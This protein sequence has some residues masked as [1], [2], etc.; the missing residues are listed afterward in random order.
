MKQI[1][2]RNAGARTTGAWVAAVIAVT[3]LVCAG[4]ESPASSGSGDTPAAFTGLTANG[5]ATETTTKLTLTFDKDITGLTAADITLTAGTT[6]VVKGALAKLS[7]T[8][9]YELAVSGIRASG[10]ITVT[11]DK[12]G[13]AISPASRN[14]EVFYYA[15]PAT[16]TVAFSSVAANGSATVT[17]TKLTLTFDKDIAGLAA[18]DITL[19]AGS[20]GTAKGALTKA[21]GTGVYELAVSGITSGG[22]I[23]VAAAKSGYSF[24]P[25]SRNVTVFYYAASATTAAAFSSVAANGS[26]TET[27]TK[28]TL[29]FDKDIAGL[30]AGDIIL[31]PGSTGAAKGALTK[32][33]GTG[34]YELAVSG[35]TSGGQAMVTVT[36]SGYSFTPGS[37]NVTVY[38][39]APVITYTV[40][41][42]GNAN[43]T[44]TALTLAFSADPGSLAIG[45]ITLGGNASKGSAALTGSGTTRTLSS[46]TVSASGNA[47]VSISR[48]G[49]ESVSKTVQVF[50]EEAIIDPNPYGLVVKWYITQEYANAE[51]AF[52]G[53]LAYE[54]TADGRILVLGTALFTYTATNNAITVRTSGITM[55]TASYAIDGTE[56]TLSNTGTSG[57]A[58]GTYYKKGDGGITYTVTANGNANTTT[59]ALTFAFSADPGSL[60]IND[61]T[62]SG[63]ASKGSATLTGS[64]TTRTLALITV[65]ASGSATVSISRTGIESGS[66]TVQVY[67]EGDGGG[68]ES[69]SFTDLTANGST[70]ETTTI[71]TLTFDKD[72]TGLSADD[73]I[74]TG[75]ST[76]AVKGTLTKL[77]G[78]GVYELAVN[79]ISAVG[80]VSIDISKNGYTITPSSR[81]VM[82]LY[83][84]PPI[85]ATFSSLTANGSATETTTKLTLTFDKNITGLSEAD[86]TLT[87]G[88]TNAVKGTLTKL[89][90]TGVYELAVSGIITGG[91]VSVSVVKDGYIISPVSRDIS[92]FY[93]VSMTFTGLTAN[94]S[95]TVTTT[96]LTLTFDQ[97]ISG[98]SA[99]DITLSGLSGITKGALD[100]SGS[101]YTL[102]V[103]GFNA[104]GELM[105]AISKDGYAISPAYRNV[106]L[107]KAPDTGIGIGSASVKLYLDSVTNPLQEKG[108]TSITKGNG[109]F[110][111]SLADGSYSGIIWYVNGDIAAQGASVTSIN[112]SKR[113]TRTFMVTVEAI[114]SGGAKNTGT[115]TFVVVE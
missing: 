36:K 79:G 25:G 112:L 102:G 54:F 56:L 10:Q 108:S 97:I 64:G 65:S 78:T 101:S 68:V 73:I 104:G 63:N 39:V 99:N 107:Y 6:L 7:G 87:N 46:V 19:T 86:I 17:T 81:N 21:A 77:A 95:A 48:T 94:G 88:S 100:G 31:S 29:T 57:L 60:T 34:V 98:L 110:T 49:I 27:T 89:A 52:P 15:A 38:Y 43:T 18:A 62:L 85:T 58:A 37:R 20:T 23:T 35:I 41:A 32:A 42:N 96:H 12:D 2:S 30:A 24:T 82:V 45:N 70:S 50:K 11:A 53:A 26:A 111:V 14:V 72:I 3:V 105:V 44:T 109:V 84:N 5:S 115:H 61:I 106:N 4:C 113:T 1:S 103:S 71:L 80:T 55:G 76:G 47:T 8:G 40:T 93:A 51:S 92:I 22:Q 33:A 59:T 90:G 91:M 9:L 67:K 69:V 13:Y 28:L 83:Y 114:P 75:G 66:K 74:L 16:V